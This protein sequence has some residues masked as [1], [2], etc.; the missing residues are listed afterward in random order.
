[1][2]Q[3]YF[4]RLDYLQRTYFERLYFKRSYSKRIFC[5][6]HISTAILQR[7]YFKRPYFQRLYFSPRYIY[8][9]PPSW[10]PHEVILPSPT[11]MSSLS[12]LDSS[13]SSSDDDDE[14]I[15]SA[16]HI[17]HRQYQARN[18]PRWGGSVVGRE[19]IHRDRVGGAWRLYN[20][21]FSENPTYGPTFFRRRFAFNP[22]NL[23]SKFS[24][25]PFLLFSYSYF[26]PQV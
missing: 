5:N 11:E 16:L 6:G 7:S 14:L 26:F 20:D 18:V 10:F 23:V 19:Y 1:M 2:Q 3:L 4:Q 17:A 13:S 15:L 25:H 9:C 12:R 8:A 22:P 21:Y 24:V